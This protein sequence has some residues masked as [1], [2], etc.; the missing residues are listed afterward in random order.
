MAE[1]EQAQHGP[2]LEEHELLREVIQRLRAAG[3]REDLTACLDEFRTFAAKHFALEEAPGGFYETVRTQAPRH[4]AVLLDLEDEHVELL[5]DTAELLAKLRSCTDAELT[6]VVGGVRSLT[7]RL[8]N[9]EGRE[10]EILLE[11]MN[12]DLGAGD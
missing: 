5:R 11:S 1:R 3:S 9:H 10:N 6:T 2:V 7:E 12:T 4:Q 8:L